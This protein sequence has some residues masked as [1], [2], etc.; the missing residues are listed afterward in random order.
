MILLLPFHSYF[1]T[2]SIVGFK[3]NTKCGIIIDKLT[4]NQYNYHKSHLNSVGVE[5]KLIIQYDS[6][7]E[8]QIA[9][10]NDYYTV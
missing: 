10:A 7:I 6:K 5:N 1:D 9:T 8:E 2:G 4:P 3:N